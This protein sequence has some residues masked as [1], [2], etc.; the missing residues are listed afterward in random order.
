MSQLKQPHGEFQSQ[1]MRVTEAQLLA[2]FGHKE[3]GDINFQKTIG[4]EK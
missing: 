4:T 3:V 1:S 2:D